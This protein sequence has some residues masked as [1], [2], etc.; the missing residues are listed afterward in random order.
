MS[1]G[2]FDTSDLQLMRPI[3]SLAKWT[4]GD[5]NGFDEYSAWLLNRFLAVC[6]DRMQL[7]QQTNQSDPL[8]REDLQSLYEMVMWLMEP[9]G[10]QPLT[11]Q[12]VEKLSY[13]IAAVYTTTALY[14]RDNKPA[15]FLLDFLALL[16][17]L[18]SLVDRKVWNALAEIGNGTSEVAKITD[19]YLMWSHARTN[20]LKGANLLRAYRMVLRPELEPLVVRMR[21][22]LEL[23]D[24]VVEHPV[25]LPNLDLMRQDVAYIR[26]SLVAPHKPTWPQSSSPAA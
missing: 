26:E 3:F 6:I 2:A 4:I 7:L 16:H 10:P 17:A 22:Y 1:Y 8:L 18:E 14:L 15:Q 11:L 13:V 23:F 25:A 20:T 5:G 24:S 19:R 12:G 21:E 9:L